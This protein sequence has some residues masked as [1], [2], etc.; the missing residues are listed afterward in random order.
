M[1]AQLNLAYAY[2]RGTG[3]PKSDKDALDWYRRAAEQGSAAAQ[4][5]LGFAYANGKGVPQSDSEAVFWY[6]KSAEQG[7]PDAQSNLGFMYFNGRG[8]PQDYIQ[9]HMWT[10]LAASQGDEVAKKN[11]EAL[12]R[13]MTQAQMAEAQ[14]LARRW[15]AKSPEGSQPAAPQAPPKG[16]DPTISGTGFA[17][18]REGHILTAGHLVFGCRNLAVRSGERQET[19]KVAAE[20]PSNDLALLGPV[21]FAPPALRLSENDAVSLGQDVVVAGYPLTGRAAST[22]ALATGRVRGTIG[23]RGDTRLMQ[24]TANVQPGASGGPLLDRAGTAVGVAVSEL[25][26]LHPSGSTQ[27]MDLALKNVVVRR[28][29]DGA[30][31]KYTITPPAPALDLGALEEAVKR[32]VVVVECWR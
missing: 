5:N 19:V 23:P 4:Y 29:L 28:F 26:P 3:I 30:G 25:S 7:Y 9:A 6:R 15:Q 31:V 12:T 27:E 17:V 20:D 11:R 1:E 16:A 32:S 8:V 22:M 2:A 13:A 18:S 10:N 21:G 14:E 24:I